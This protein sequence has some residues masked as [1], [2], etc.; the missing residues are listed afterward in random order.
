[1]RDVV[2]GRLSPR[3]NVAALAAIALAGSL[4]MGAK[5]PAGGASP[6]V[7]V[8]LV[9]YAATG[10]KRAY[11]MSGAAETGATF[12]VKSGST[13]VLSGAGRCG[14]GLVEQLVRPRLRD[15]LRFAHDVGTYTIAVS[16]PAPATSVPFTIGTAAAVHLQPLRNALSYY[17]VQRDGPNFVP[18]ALRTA[19]AH[20]NDATAMTYTT[21]SVN[22]NGG[23]RGD[24][25]P[26]GVTIDASGGW[27]DAGDYLKFLHATTYT[28]SLLLTGVRDF[29]AQM[30]AG[31]AADFT[32]EAKF[33]ADW[34][35]RMWDDPSRTLYYQV[36]IGDGN[37]QDRQRPRHLAAAPGRRRVRRDRS[38]LPVHPEPAGLPGRPSGLAHQPEPRRT[39]RRRARACLQVFRTSDPAFANRASSPRPA[40]LRPRQHEPG[41]S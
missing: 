11:L 19:A 38:A 40:H 33:G 35:L 39:R 12:A 13:T 30:G 25:S 3:R 24:L 14:P 20:L 4:A 23:F 34:I 41:R 5:P 28:D 27:W 31:G 32:A 17:Q 1:M 21:P 16:G 10:T 36:G 37:A 2:S 26:L 18:S 15:R 8:N 29:P 6:Q 9:G 7:R 22:R